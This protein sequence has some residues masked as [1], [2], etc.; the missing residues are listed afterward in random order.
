MRRGI[1]RHRQRELAA[2]A[3]GVAYVCEVWF[4]GELWSDA[5]F[6]ALDADGSVY[7]ARRESS[8]GAHAGLSGEGGVQTMRIDEVTRRTQ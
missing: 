6:A 3:W 7:V 8:I 1:G 2:G 5:G 4:E